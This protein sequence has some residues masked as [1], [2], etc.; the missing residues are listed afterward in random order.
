MIFPRCAAVVHHG[1]IGTVAQALAAGIPQLVVPFAHD[2][3]DNACRV[4]SLGA[5]DYIVPGKY[6][7]AAAERG[8]QV[9]LKSSAVGERCLI[10]ASRISGEK[11]LTAACAIMEERLAGRAPA[12]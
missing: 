7:P 9:L 8:L 5:G 4:R 11:A 2:Q 10:L 3:P 12:T 6:G 1:G